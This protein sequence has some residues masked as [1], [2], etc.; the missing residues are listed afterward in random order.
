MGELARRAA[1]YCRISF[2]PKE[3]RVG[4]EAQERDCRR[5]IA[6]RGWEAIEPAYVD[7]GKSAWS[8]KE[9]PEWERLKR[10]IAAGK[11][12]AVVVYR[13]SR[14][15]RDVTEQEAILQTF[16]A[17]DFGGIRSP[18]SE[19]S[20]QLFRGFRSPAEGGRSGGVR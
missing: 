18:V 20:D 2:D 5:F 7:N 19:E 10:D 8:G 6:S 4:T 3:R 9:R 15:A 11:V 17:A 14:L 1:V 12:G 13:L 16:R